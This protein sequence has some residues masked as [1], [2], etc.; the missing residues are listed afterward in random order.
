MAGVSRRGF[1]AGATSVGF[2]VGAAALAGCSR[3]EETAMQEQLAVDA[4]ADGE[5]ELARALVSFDGEHQ[6]GIATSAQAHLNLVGFDLRDGVAKQ[7]LANLLRLWT[8]DARA[9]CTAEAPLGSLEPEMTAVPANLTVTCGLSRSVFEFIGVPA[10]ESLR[11]IQAFDR[12]ALDPAWGQSDLVLQI[13]S[14]DP[15][16]ASYCLRHMVRSSSDYV[17]VK[18]LQQGFSHAHGSYQ[19]GES[20][21]NLFAQ[22]DGTINPRSDEEFDAQVWIDEGPQW[23]RG[24]TGMV[25]RRIRMNLDTWEQ[26]DRASRE[27]AVGRRLID[28]APLTG[29]AEHDPADF[30]AKDKYGLPI[31]DKNSHMARATAPQDHPEQKILRRPY[32]YELAPDPHTP[33]Q[34]SNAGQIFI[35]FQKDPT[36]QFEPIQRRLDEADLL[37]EWITHVGSAV[38]FCPPG[39]HA[40]SGDADSWWA[41]SLFAEAGL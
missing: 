15:V 12:D 38:Y 2:G 37:N 31:I 14:D 29:Q 27:N 21:R 35:C 39:T 33:D 22:V 8:E 4:G 3:A 19:P 34:L 20:A 11:D 16:V 40:G 17:L 1:I 10:P 36:R 26:L 18:W 7:E 9:L 23:A 32:N 30:S 5:P 13:C 28:G 25:I 24:G 41:Q 6:A